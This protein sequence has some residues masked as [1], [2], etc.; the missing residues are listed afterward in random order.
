M[1]TYN[2]SDDNATWFTKL[3]DIAETIGYAREVKIWKK[4]KD[5]WPGH[6]GDISTTIRVAI[7]SR[8]NTPDLCQIMK[9]LGPKRIKERFEYALKNVVDYIHS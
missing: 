9:I 5:I 8:S 6:V 1:K 2:P 7:T 4:E 3:K